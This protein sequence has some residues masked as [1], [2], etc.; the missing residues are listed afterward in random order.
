MPL[1]LCI[2]TTNGSLGSKKLF[3][4]NKRYLESYCKT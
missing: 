1:T 3:N 2:E 4:N